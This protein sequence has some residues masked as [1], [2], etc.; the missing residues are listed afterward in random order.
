MLVTSIVINIT[1]VVGT[2]EIMGNR[3]R[4]GDT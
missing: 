1:D 4:E 3:G 2:N